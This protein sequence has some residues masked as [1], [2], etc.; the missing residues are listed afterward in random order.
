[1]LCDSIPTSLPWFVKWCSVLKTVEIS[2]LN[3]K[4]HALS[5]ILIYNIRF[6]LGKIIYVEALLTLMYGFNFLELLSFK[7]VF[8]FFFNRAHSKYFS[9][10]Y[11]C[12][13][14]ERS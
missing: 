11:K 12:K 8:F 9:S 4:V 14:Q 1:M 3:S 5:R 2:F 13:L 6:C 10:N 7:E